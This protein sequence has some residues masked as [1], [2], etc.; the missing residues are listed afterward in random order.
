MNRVNTFRQQI[1]RL[2]QRLRQRMQQVNHAS[3][4]ALR[5]LCCRS[6]DPIHHSDHNNTP[7]LP[8]PDTSSQY[9]SSSSPSSI[10]QIPYQVISDSTPHSA[11]GISA[12]AA[13]VS[14]INLSLPATDNQNASSSS[15]MVVDASSNTTQ[16]L[17][18]YLN[19]WVNEAPNERDVRQRVKDQIQT[20]NGQLLGDGS[21]DLRY[22]IVSSL[23]QG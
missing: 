13:S 17:T 8:L 1:T 3:N 12:E 6:I 22:T 10:P 5:A 2:P 19:N 7:A 23:P 16:D 9:S 21:L 15:L 20:V 18:T 14:D 11:E 4:Q